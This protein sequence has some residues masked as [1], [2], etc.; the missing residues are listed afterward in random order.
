MS[1]NAFFVVVIVVVDR[2]GK[3]SLY[4]EENECNRLFTRETKT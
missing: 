3:S 2:S 4:L 1:P